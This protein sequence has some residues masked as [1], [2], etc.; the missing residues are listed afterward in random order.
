MSKEIELVH[1]IINFLN[2]NMQYGDDWSKHIDALN[3]LLLNQ[4]KDE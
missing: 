2:E 1:E 3:K 4:N